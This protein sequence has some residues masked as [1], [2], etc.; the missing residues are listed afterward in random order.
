MNARNLFV[1][2]AV[3]LVA[4][5]AWVAIGW[6]VAWGAD[7]PKS[8]VKPLRIL[9][10]VG[11]ESAAMAQFREFLRENYHVEITYIDQSKGLAGIEAL[12]HCDV[13]VSN[14]RRTNPT[15]EQL[16]II[17]KYC[18]AGKPVVGLRRAHHGFQNW[19][20]ADREIFGVKYGG[21]G[22]GGKD[23]PLNIPDDQKNNPL[24]EGFKPFLPG[25]GLYHHTELDPKATVLMTSTDKGKAY[26]Q[27]WT[28]VHDNGQ[29][30]FYTRFDPTDVMKDEGVRN[31]V[32]R[33]ICWAAQRDI[34]EL[35]K[36]K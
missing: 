12:D 27:M 15:P 18:A 23:A 32:V 13:F 36:K 7:S 35:K 16:A 29:R 9:M 19:L 17:K 5:H 26:P 25:G 21:H 31:V 4:P 14:L 28:L 11:P 1:R 30:V 2:L 8:P 20:E 34:N 6:T 10:A 22:G 24:L 3:L 33:A